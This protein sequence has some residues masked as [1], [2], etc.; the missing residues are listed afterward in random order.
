MKLT[1]L[2]GFPGSC[3]STWAT[4]Q[5]EAVVINQDILGS[6]QNCIK[7]CKYYME[8]KAEHI[9]IDRTNISKKQ[10]KYWTDLAKQYGITDINCI[11]FK[12]S[13]EECIKRIK[14]RKDHK[15]ITSE[16]SLDKI[17]S[18]VLQFF[19]DYEE[20][21]FQEGFSSIS[22]LHIDNLLK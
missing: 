4:D 11:V 9:I 14:S 10:R 2:V 13:Q 19:H 22:I 16:T 20:P 1:V 18:I 12:S 3:K 5:K 7:E 6:R 15:T 8:N 17:T 21:T